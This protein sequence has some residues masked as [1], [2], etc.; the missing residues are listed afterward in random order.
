MQEQAPNPT[1]RILSGSD[2][3]L[4]LLLVVALPPNTECRED[5]PFVY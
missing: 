3:T 1:S 5:P 2:L 4:L